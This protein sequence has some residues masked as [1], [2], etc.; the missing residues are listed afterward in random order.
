MISFGH[1]GNFKKTEKFLDQARKL[2]YSS[3]LHKYGKQGVDALS[4]ATPTDTG[5]TASSWYYDIV[6]S[7]G[8]YK[9]VWSN[10]N[11]VDGVPI[12]ILIQ[13]GHGTGNG[14]YVPGIDYINP[15]IRPIIQNIAEAVWKEVSRL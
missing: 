1:K 2:N 8:S 3:I 11:V 14:G 15:A 6:M 5:K 9:I 7:N 12:A 13:F 4:A 10:S